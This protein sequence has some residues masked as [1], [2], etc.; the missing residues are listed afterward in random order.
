MKNH[1]FLFAT[2]V[3][4]IACTISA[5]NSEIKHD[6][7]SEESKVSVI[8]EVSK[9]SET[10]KTSTT[11]TVSKAESKSE[12]SK[13]ESKAESKTETGVSE[14]D[15][16]IVVS[17]ESEPEAT[18]EEVSFI[19]SEESYE[20]RE[21]SVTQISEE[22]VERPSTPPIT[23]E[24]IVEIVELQV[25]SSIETTS[26]PVGEA[27]KL[28]KPNE[29]SEPSEVSES[30]EQSE[31]SA[32]SSAAESSE[33]SGKSELSETQPT[34]WAITTKITLLSN[35]QAI[36]GATYVKVISD[37]GDYCTIEWYGDTAQVSRFDIEV[38]EVPAGQEDVILM[39]KT[40][41][42]ITAYG[43]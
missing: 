39:R 37:D 43:N 30:S 3:I 42:V 13:V 28:S 1:N 41:G 19:F 23:S 14:D 40:A 2:C 6:V 9:T 25:E 20:S 4:A 35:G 11:S 24:P 10:P 33:E 31:E 29:I 5:C 16:E 21:P 12:Q 15:S 32:E 34:K 7:S 18:R 27:S 36:D 26:E 38:F 8:S 22:V 17:S